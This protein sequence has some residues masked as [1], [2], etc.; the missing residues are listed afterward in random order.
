MNHQ[1][2]NEIAPEIKAIFGTLAFAA[3]EIASRKYF[4]SVVGA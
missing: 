1:H 2:P 4:L 3:E